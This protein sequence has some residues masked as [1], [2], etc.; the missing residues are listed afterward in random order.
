MTPATF[1]N[2]TLQSY[3]IYDISYTSSVRDE[4]SKLKNQ[5][6]DHIL[7][8]EQIKPM[9][10]PSRELLKIDNSSIKPK[11]ENENSSRPEF[12]S[13]FPRDDHLLDIKLSKAMLN[14]DSIGLMPPVEK[15]TIKLKITK[16]KEGT[17]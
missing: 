10:K 2:G 13:Q 8:K 4:S 14:Y 6:I 1:L 11:I 15:S 12:F 5:K 3:E 7:R 9:F 17:P 16:I